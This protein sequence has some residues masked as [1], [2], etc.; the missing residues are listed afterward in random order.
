MMVPD[1]AGYLEFRE[2]FGAVMDPRYFPLEWLDSRI[3]AGAVRFWRND[4][5]AIVAELRRYPGG[6]LDVHG[7]VAAGELAGV[8]ELIALAE[9]WGA[10]QPGFV[11]A[12]ISSRPAWAKALKSHGYKLHQT[13][14]RKEVR[15]GI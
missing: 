5:A 11:A 10:E 15:D 1:W 13:T 8:I 7:L 9:E 14:V 4:T 2:R 3:L 6:A 12:E